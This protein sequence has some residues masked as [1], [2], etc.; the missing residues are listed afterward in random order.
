LQQ[1]FTRLCADWLRNLAARES[2]D[3]RNEASV[4]LAR[5][6]LPILDRMPLPFI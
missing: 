6:A 5:E 1:S 4:K 3:L 2:F